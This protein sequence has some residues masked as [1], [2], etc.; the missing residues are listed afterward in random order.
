MFRWGPDLFKL[1]ENNYLKWHELHELKECTV[2]LTIKLSHKYT[3]KTIN[4]TI[5][6]ISHK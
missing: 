1:N 4:I 2:T 3:F 6:L 5:K